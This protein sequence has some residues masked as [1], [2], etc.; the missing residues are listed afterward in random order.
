MD[1][2]RLSVAPSKEHRTETL[3][4]LAVVLVAA[5]FL[6]FA[7]MRTGGGAGGGATRVTALFPSANGISVGT[8]V[9]VA[10]MKVG[11]VAGQRLDPKSFQAEVVLALNREVRIPADSSAAIQSESLLGG[12]HVALVP[13]ASAEPLKSGDVIM[14]TQGSVDMMSLIGG[15]INRTGGAAEAAPATGGLGTMDETTP[16]PAAEPTP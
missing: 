10:G 7:W 1:A 8:D 16:A 14:D 12:S 9:R 2:G 15:M 11:Q 4:G 3:A 6:L 5:A 13:G